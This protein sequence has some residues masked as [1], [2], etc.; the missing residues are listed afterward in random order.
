MGMTLPPSQGKQ[1]DG[2]PQ[3][4]EDSFFGASLHEGIASMLEVPNTPVSLPRWL[5]LMATV[6]QKPVSPAGRVSWTEKV[7]EKGKIV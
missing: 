6:I 1:Q 3:D 2:V 5:G 4:K 7:K